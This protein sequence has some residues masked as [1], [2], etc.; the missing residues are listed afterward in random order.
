MHTPDPVLTASVYANRGLDALI[1]GAVAPFRARLRE[2]GPAG[3]WSLWMVR[4]SRC[5]EHLK[6]R[7]HGPEEGREDA[8]RLLQEAVDAHF[9]TLA[10]VDGGVPRVSRAD[11]PA[12]D[13]ED[14]AETDYPDRALLW[15][16]YR[17]SHV[18]MGPPVHLG[19]NEYA[20]RFTAA[21]AAGAGLVLDRL[22]PD[23]EGRFAG[24]A[25]QH[26][27]LR[28]LLAAIAATGFTA[29]ERE[30][31]L[32]YHRG[33]LIRFTLDD[34]RRETEAVAAFDRRVEAMSA[35]TE[36]VRR[37]AAALWDVP[38]AAPASEGEAAWCAAV[39]ALAGYLDGLRGDPVYDVDPFAGNAVF[40]PVFKAFHGL[41]NQA[42]VGML[43]E[44]F[45]H[46][47]LLRATAAPVEAVVLAG[48]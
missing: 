38:D 26:I 31:Y 15:T 14:E 25:R 40:P 33:W 4:Y 22:A 17:R 11:A 34:A 21:M 36:Q 42:G 41:A 47:L 3:E 29:E 48:V 39:S 1:H 44:A 20:A 8:R 46:H 10:P 23:A 24:S 12:M 2:R 13:A 16:H 32:A 5:G 18:N 19:S 37:T 28:G 27:L 35:A 7:V 6:L 30:A 45:L 43:D 9:A